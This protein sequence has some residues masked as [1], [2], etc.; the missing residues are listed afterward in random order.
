MEPE[1]RRGE[2]ELK[3]GPGLLCPVRHVRRVDLTVRGLPSLLPLVHHVR[4]GVEET[5]I[6]NGKS[7]TTTCTSTSFLF[8]Y[9]LFVIM[10][11]VRE[12]KITS[13]PG[14]RQRGLGAGGW[15][16]DDVL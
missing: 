3:T 15:G 9:F 4:E 12:K 2:G 1:T 5:D 14:G 8:I 7:C 6:H 11:L 16:L 10:F 13:N